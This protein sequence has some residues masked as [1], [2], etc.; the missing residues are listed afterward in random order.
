MFKGRLGRAT[1]KRNTH[2]EPP[3]AEQEPLDAF[4]VLEERNHRR[5]MAGHKKERNRLS[6]VSKLPAE[7]VI[8]VLQIMRHDTASPLSLVR[9]THVYCR[10]REIALGCA[11]LWTGICFKACP[12]L[13]ETLIQRTGRHSLLDF[14]IPFRLSPR[15]W[16]LAEENLQSETS[17]IKTL[18]VA[19]PFVSVVRDLE[20]GMPSLTHLELENDSSASNWPIIPDEFLEGGAPELRY[21][22]L[23]NMAPRYWCTPR[24]T[25]LTHLKVQLFPR[26][27][28]AYHHT[29]DTIFDALEEMPGLLDLDLSMD[30][31]VPDQ[32]K[33]ARLSN[34]RRL[35]LKSSFNDLATFLECVLLP[36]STVITLEGTLTRDEDIAERLK[37]A[38]QAAWVSDPLG[39]SV[40]DTGPP[41]LTSLCIDS[42]SWDASSFT[43]TWGGVDEPCGTLTLNITNVS[44]SKEP[45]AWL[46]A[47]KCFGGLASLHEVMHETTTFES[48]LADLGKLK[49]LTMLSLRDPA[50]MGAFSRYAI[51]SMS[52][53]RPLYGTIPFHSLKTVTLVG[54]SLRPGDRNFEL[55][56]NFLEKRRARDEHTATR[57]NRK[58]FK[59]STLELVNCS[60]IH[61]DTLSEL[62]R[63]VVHLDS[64]RSDLSSPSREGSVE[65]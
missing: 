13:I 63:E 14:D 25:A 8:I 2:V 50:T 18:R 4:I 38:I 51:E 56:L 30:F 41:V 60:H 36:F 44:V 48:Q 33:E 26:W 16:E 22:S 7:L 19:G 3:S 35:R 65:V 23:I 21:L 55:F 57:E 64:Q 1:L 37:D 5:V 52:S 61:A 53:T 49:R 45:L 11:H 46:F 34:L 9:M 29:R 62:A 43:G 6:H 31:P 32:A 40:E 20:L 15:L 58:S 12:A 28:Y 54:I 42:D 59:I 27:E 39:G 47:S 10:W 17:R 24:I